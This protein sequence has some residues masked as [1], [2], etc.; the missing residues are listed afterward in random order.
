MHVNIYR[1]T[2]LY[3]ISGIC[4]YRHIDCENLHLYMLSVLYLFAFALSFIFGKL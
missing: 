4:D 3:A 1:V 2:L